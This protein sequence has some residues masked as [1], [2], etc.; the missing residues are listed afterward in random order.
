[1]LKSH[2]DSAVLAEKT[3]MFLILTSNYWCLVLVSYLH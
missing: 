2:T 3:Q 1:M